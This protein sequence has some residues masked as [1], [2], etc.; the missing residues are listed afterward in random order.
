MNVTT[1]KEKRAHEFERELREVY[2]RLWRA[3]GKGEIM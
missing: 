1:I 2:G 3:E